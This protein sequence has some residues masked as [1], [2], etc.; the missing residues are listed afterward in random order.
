MRRRSFVVA[1]REL[2]A[3]L[4]NPWFII[5]TIGMPLFMI[6]VTA[7]SSIPTVYLVGKEAKRAE[8]TWGLVDESG[9]FEKAGPYRSAGRGAPASRTRGAVG[10]LIGRID[11]DLAEAATRTAQRAFDLARF[12]DRDAARRAI[13]AKTARGAVVFPKDYLERGRIE[14]LVD[15]AEGELTGSEGPGRVLERWITANLLAPHV[16]VELRA[17][18]EQPLA[19]K[20]VTRVEPDGT[21]RPFDAMKQ[22]SRIA[23]PLGFAVLL[24]V[25]IMSAAG[26]LM[27][28][29][30]EEKENRVLEVLLASITPDELL[31]GKLLGLGLAG[32]LQLGVWGGSGGF[33]AAALLPELEAGPA[34]IALG[35]AYFALGYLFYGSLILGFGSL[36]ANLRDSQQW[37]AV[38]SLAGGLIPVLFLTMVLDEPHGAVARIVSIL[39]VTAPV[40]MP[41]RF[42]LG[43]VPWT[44]VA[45]SLALNA[46]SVYLALRLA[47][48]V[49]RIGTLLTGQTPGPREVWRA[50]RSG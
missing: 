25:A 21:E 16:S 45:G 26:Y 7:I 30:A 47:A 13:A 43:G 44:D 31:E 1:G 27:T 38:F 22:I 11:P 28:G 6:V 42:A 39:P 48:R 46:A 41:A 33:A 14:L 37:S 32:L 29:V 50:L 23:V 19:D 5:S 10:R 35:A 20:D 49:Y 36:G 9:L 2:L 15:A 24:M 12:P 3:V 34:V 18:V 17:R 4:K 40:C 8:G